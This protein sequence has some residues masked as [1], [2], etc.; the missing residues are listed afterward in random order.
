MHGHKCK[1]RRE[2]P[3]KHKRDHQEKRQQDGRRPPDI[4]EETRH[5]PA[6][7]LS[8]R[9]NHEIRSV[10]DVGHGAEE[11]RT[12]ADRDKECL[13]DVEMRPRQFQTLSDR[14]ERQIGRRIIKKG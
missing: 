6:A 5:F 3:E 8:D 9:A 13:G 12:H 7:V 4:S 14:H 1:R 2:L 11:D 10:P